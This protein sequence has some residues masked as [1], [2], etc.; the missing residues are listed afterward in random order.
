M[1]LE[2]H[3]SSYLQTLGSEKGRASMASRA[4]HLPPPTR[5]FTWLDVPC[6]SAPWEVGELLLG[7]A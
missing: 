7:E 5:K 4:F 3:F 2:M 6:K 1:A